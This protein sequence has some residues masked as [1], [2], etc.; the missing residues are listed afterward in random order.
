MQTLV[1]L[2]L[3][4]NASLHA[5]MGSSDSQTLR[6]T[7]YGSGCLRL[8]LECCAAGQPAGSLITASTR[9]EGNIAGQLLVMVDIIIRALASPRPTPTLSSQAE[10]SSTT[11]SSQPEAEAEAEDRPARAVGPL[12]VA[13]L[14][15][16]PPVED[17]V[18][19]KAAHAPS[20]P[21]R[22]VLAR[23]ACQGSIRFNCELPPG[24][25]YM[26]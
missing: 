25:I 16:E 2:L 17:A 15:D 22:W 6:A 9:R 3:P 26:H 20:S 10:D 13:D 5:Q 19:P 11:V 4:S 24:C 1:A 18:T 8:V 7:F 23:Q 14:A 12:V 21:T